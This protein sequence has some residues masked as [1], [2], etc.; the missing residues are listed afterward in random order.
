MK[1]VVVGA[2]PAGVTA[3]EILRAGDP[4]ADILLV[5]DEPGPAYSRMA[6]PYLL[7][8]DIEESGTHLRQQP[9]HFENL[10]IERLQAKVTAVAPDTRTLI[11][12]DGSQ[13]AY[14]RLLIATGSRP[15]TP[16]IDGLKGPRV[17]HCWTL[18]DARA[19]ADKAQPGSRVTLMGAGFIGC[20]I[21]E[22]LVKRGVELTVIEMGDR[23]VPRMMD[24]TAGNLLKRWCQEKGVAVHTSTR[25][26]SVAL[27]ADGSLQVHC[28]TT[29][30]VATDLLVV[31]AGVRPQIEFL[32]SSSIETGQGIQVDEYLQSSLSGVYAAGDVC[33]THDWS[34]GEPTVMAIQPVAV[35]TGRVA[36]LNM[37]GRTTPY[38]G[39]LAMNV[40]DTLGLISASFGL[41]MGVENGQQAEVLDD[42]GYR[43]IRLQFDEDR[44]VGA[45]ALGMTEHVGVLRGL[46]QGR[47]A[48]G[49]WKM[50]L[51]SDPTRIMEAYLAR[52]AFA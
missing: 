37:L 51:I 4:E 9:G 47:V 28:D 23:M 1:Y 36:A 50:R 27:K 32:G 5:G 19:I 13:R 11:L 18:A 26:E 14:D 21:L 44:L 25:I 12:D 52:C 8:G 38:Q 33:E 7:A 48:L 41:W 15:V 3:V 42:A 10:G 43:Y 16:P 39:A 35:E 40:L 46:I 22:A 34:S 17:Q 2:G 45:I 6:I 24:Q 29:D 20:I 31:A 30:P 49:E